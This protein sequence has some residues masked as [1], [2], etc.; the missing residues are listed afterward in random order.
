[1]VCCTG[2][3]EDEE[4]GAVEEE[5]DNHDEEERDLHICVKHVRTFT[6]HQDF[7]DE[8][9]GTDYCGSWRRQT[10]NSIR[11]PGYRPGVGVG[12]WMTRK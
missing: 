4:G 7:K 2:H 6:E 1:M 3:H 8:T 10:R 5:D 12:I 11:L 9:A